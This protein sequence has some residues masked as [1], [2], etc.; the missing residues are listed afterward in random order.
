[1]GDTLGTVAV[2][3]PAHPVAL[4]LLAETGPLAV[5]S[6]NLTGHPAATSAQNA[7]DQL[8]ARVE[9]YLDGG[10][11]TAGEPSTIIDATPLQRGT[12]PV[13]V[14]RDGVVTVAQLRSILGDDLESETTSLGSPGSESSEEPQD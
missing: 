11:A 7:H 2:R 5:S 13:R 14:L 9:V 10:Q 3:V 4:E 12:G 6:A 8:G 1:L